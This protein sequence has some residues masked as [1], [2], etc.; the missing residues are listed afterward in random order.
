MA[1]EA[2]IL[3]AAAQLG[4]KPTQDVVTG[5]WFIPEFEGQRTAAAVTNRE[6]VTAALTARFQNDPYY[7]T[8]AQDLYD[9]Y[10]EEALRTGVPNAGPS[11]DELA[12]LG[13]DRI[14]RKV[15]NVMSKL[16]GGFNPK[17]EYVNPDTG[18][19][20]EPNRFLRTAAGL[21]NWE[22]Q[23]F[24]E[25]I[26]GAAGVP[27]NKDFDTI[28]TLL[29]SGTPV[30]G[31]PP[32]IPQAG[33]SASNVPASTTN[34]G[35]QGGVY[36]QNPSNQVAAGLVAEISADF[37][38]AS[39]FG[40]LDM[41]KELAIEDA[42]AE[43]IVAELRASDVYKQ[44]FPGMAGAGGIRRFDN[45]AAYITA[46]RNIRNVLKDYGAYDPATDSPMDY[47]AFF[48]AGIDSNELKERFDVYRELERGSQDLRN[49]FFVYGGMDVSVDD[50]FQAVVSPQF[51]E[52][53]VNTYDQ[54]VAS[55]PLDYA[56]YIDRARQVSTNNVVETLERMQARGDMT[57][58]AV[59][60]VLQLDP[61]FG[62]E[63]MGA[64]FTGGG[65]AADTQTLSLSELTKAYEYAI[66]GGA[67][68]NA[69]FAIPDKARLE[70]F[71]QAGIDSA[72]LTSAYSNLGQ[73][74]GALSGM[75]DRANRGN[76]L[77]RDLFDEELLGRSREIQF[78]Q[79]G[80]RALGARGGGFQMGQ[81]GRR[82]TQTGRST[83]F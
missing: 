49:A 36:N 17:T 42:T 20:F 45:E 78:A 63:L 4:I 48:D 24:G 28:M 72:K 40:F 68:S 58:T 25:V 74:A 11:E 23:R 35:D 21:G 12:F 44:N 26:E 73:R 80:E 67:A 81:E 31:Q 50:L 76:T 54:K 5:S 22:A 83:R 9:F 61:V 33:M 62:Q 51:R 14:Q 41:I 75:L 82:F 69:G 52:E 34:L 6:D 13:P 70:E 38:W 1:T 30:T 10:E 57:G 37:P 7:S 39:E 79:A 56:T 27:R 2:A 3:L 77:S 43:Q 53:L 15:D 32:V 55:Q 65:S 71:R 18:E 47:V 59:S 29:E 19:A 60:R 8:T 64:L 66:M 16:E 46:R